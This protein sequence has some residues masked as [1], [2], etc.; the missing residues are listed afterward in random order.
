MEEILAQ[1]F[2]PFDFSVVSG[3]PNPVP[4]VDELQGRLPK[5]K[6]CIDDNPTEHFLEFHE[7]MHHLDIFHED[8]LMNMFMY[9]LEGDAREWYQSLPHSSISSLK[10]FHT[11]FH[12][13]CRR[14]FP[15]EC[16]FEHCCEEF[17]SYI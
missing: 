10:Q 6:E 13:H 3:Y 9:S 15:A 7:M 1:I 11:V 2:V 5:F 8:V 16:L 17:A 14:Y 4:H 12:D